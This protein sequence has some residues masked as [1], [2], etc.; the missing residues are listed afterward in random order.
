MRAAS[1]VRWPPP[2]R[3]GDLLAVLAPASPVKREAFRAGVKWLE[4]WGFRV[5]Y[6]EEIFSGR[7]WDRDTDR[8]LAGQLCRVLAE[9]EVRGV[10]CARGGYGSLKLLEHLDEES[11]GRQAKVLVGFSDITNLLCHFYR[12]LGLVTFHGPNVAH[13][14]EASAA[15]RA[16]L[17]V[18]LTATR[19]HVQSFDKLDVLHPGQGAGPLAGGNLTTLC[20]LVGTPFLPRLDGHVVFLEDHGE[21]G[22]RVDRMLHHLRL[23]GALAGVRGIVLGSFTGGGDAEKISGIAAAALGGLGLPVLAGL[24][25]GHQP[26]NHTLPVGGWAEVDGARG[27]LTII[28]QG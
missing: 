5:R 17:W 23:S 9:P 20:H 28:F 22:Y 15:A 25:V 4:E 12:R 3:S 18:A 24:P 7:P 11:L 8:E 13:L 26:E 21:A 10:I 27:T 1:G 16:S 2:L 6:G 19:P 14:G